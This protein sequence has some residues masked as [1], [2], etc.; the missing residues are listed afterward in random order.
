MADRT[1]PEAAQ[2]EI[3]AV[4]RLSKMPGGKQAEVAVLVTDL[5]QRQG[6]GTEL[7]QRLIEIARDEKLPRNS[8]PTFFLKIS[9]CVRWRTASVCEFPRKR[10]SRNARC[11]SKS[12]IPMRRQS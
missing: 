3:L 8:L 6:L 5:Y 12:L 10:R 4:G 2:H 7:L 9:R 11:G 1:T